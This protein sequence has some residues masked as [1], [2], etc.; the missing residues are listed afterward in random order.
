MPAPGDQGAADVAWGDT[1]YMVVWIGYSTT[2]YCNIIRSD[3]TYIRDYF[4]VEDAAIASAQ[5]QALLQRGVIRTCCAKSSG[6]SIWRRSISI[7]ATR[8]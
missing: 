2:L 4:Y 6:R 7:T 5:P 3:G 8:Q 1:S